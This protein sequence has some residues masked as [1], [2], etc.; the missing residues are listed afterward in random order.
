M[1][2]IVLF[3]GTFLIRAVFSSDSNGVQQIYKQI[4]ENSVIFYH[5]LMS[6]GFTQFHSERGGIFYFYRQL[7]FNV[8]LRILSVI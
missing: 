8:Y 2:L 4:Q 7:F 1:E 3:Y 6:Q 5:Q